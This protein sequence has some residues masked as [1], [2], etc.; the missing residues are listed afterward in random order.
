MEIASNYRNLDLS[1]YFKT[2]TLDTTT[3][4][5]FNGSSFDTILQNQT[6]DGSR[7]Q[8]NDNYKDYL[9]RRDGKESTSTKNRK[10]KMVDK[11]NDSGQEVNESTKDKN[12]KDI[13]TEN[14][15]TKD[16][17]T[18]DVDTENT[19]I[20]TIE[21]EEIE[22][23]DPKDLENLE[24]VLT[25]EDLQ[26]GS[27][28]INEIANLLNISVDELV[29]TLSD[30]NLDFSS[31]TDSE[32][33]KNLLMAINGLSDKSEL[34]TLNNLKET[35]NGIQELLKNTQSL[36]AADSELKNL[37]DSALKALEQNGE[38][39]EN[40]DNTNSS[41]VQNLNANLATTTTTTTNNSV[42]N[43][44]LNATVTAN[45]EENV[46][47]NANT[48][49][50][51]NQDSQMQNSSNQS[52]NEEA[53]RMPDSNEE[54]IEIPQMQQETTTS[55]YTPEISSGNLLNSMNA[56]TVE[57]THTAKSSLA[58]P[59][60]DINVNSNVTST[61]NNSFVSQ[62]ARTFTG[63]QV[64]AENV[65]KQITEAMQIE[66]VGDIS[67]EIKISLKPA[68]LG[69][70]M[71]SI[72]SENGIITAKFEAESLR[73]K[74]IIESNFNQLKDSLAEQGIEISNLEVT[75]RQDTPSNDN[76]NLNNN[77]K[78]NSQSGSSNLNNGIDGI[79]DDEI[80]ET[81]IDESEAVGSKN[82]YKV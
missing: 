17:N 64:D 33:V 10:D 62:T 67:N 24:N 40:V 14:V 35:L 69:D 38:D 41:T 19:E 59:T 46:N 50:N 28:I 32:N 36:D 48:D 29:E 56:E 75:I 12:T 79:S 68:H 54:E 52:T 5:S 43:E 51:A 26:L 53:I 49:T 57:L 34:L 4:S 37:I 25:A 1:E 2:Q 78:N 74:E 23:I 47:F 6:N 70:V 63:S 80:V 3:D 81:V 39:V 44:N 13:D 21:A 82:S 66:V 27:E 16:I 7:P 20:E 8:S 72:L 71:L 73:I 58:E 77:S 45:S 18:E 31:L 9:E 11:K 60:M 55:E 22:V 42:V 76:S 65:M 30:L 15:D 61:N